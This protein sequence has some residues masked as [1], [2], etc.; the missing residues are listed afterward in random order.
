MKGGRREREYEREDVATVDKVWGFSNKQGNVRSGF[1]WWESFIWKQCL[2]KGDESAVRSH[3]AYR[4]SRSIE[5]AQPQTSF[6]LNGQLLRPGDVS[7]DAVGSIC[8]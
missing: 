7:G 4:S 6:V 1:L 2:S 5:Q 3:V 8:F